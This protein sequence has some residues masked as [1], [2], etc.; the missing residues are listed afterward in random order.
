MIFCKIYDEKHKRKNELLDFS[1]KAEEKEKDVSLRIKNLFKSVKSS[2]AGVIDKNEHIDLEEGS[3]SFVVSELQNLYLTKANRSVISEAFEVFIG[4]S[5]KGDKGQFF[6]PRNVVNTI[7]NI[8]NPSTNQLIID[9]AC[10]SG[11]FLVKSLMSLWEKNNQDSVEYEWTKEEKSKRDYEIAANN[12][13]GIDKDAFL[14]K[15]T[16]AYMAIVG[17]G[18]SN[19][20]CDDSLKNLSEFQLRNKN[21]IEL[22]KFDFVLTNPPFGKKIKID[23]KKILRN[24]DLAHLWSNR[25]GQFIKGRLKKEVEPQIL[26]IERCVNLLRDGGVT[27][28]VLPES[29]FHAP[30]LKY[31]LHWVKKHCKIKAIIDLPFATFQ[32]YAGI[33]SCVLIAQK[34]QESEN[35]ENVIVMATAE[36]VGHDHRGRQTSA[37]TGLEFPDDLLSIQNEWKFPSNATNSNVMVVNQNEIIK[38]YY[39][40]RYYKGLK[41]IENE[42]IQ[43]GYEFEKI[44]IKEL[45][46]SRQLKCFNGLG[47]PKGESKGREGDAYYL[48]TS[49][50]I[51]FELYR[52][53]T[54]YIPIDEFESKLNSKNGYKILKFKDV[55]MVRRGGQRIGNIAMVSPNDVNDNILYASELLNFRV[56]DSTKLNPYLLLFLLSNDFVKK[57]IKYSTFIDSHFPNLDN[58]YLEI[59]LLFPKDQA[60]VQSITANIQNA[61]ENRWK[62]WDLLNNVVFNRL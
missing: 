11:E 20:L 5:L 46:E 49:D 1:F 30:S 27:A 14:A 16:K 48:R 37:I 33:K 19:I 51:N 29:I 42:T 45:I 6:T 54:T 25:D 2:Y 7:V 17:D 56:M 3:I 41:I 53:P 36:N 31:I 44:S 10:G 39:I 28:I 47:S 43:C 4:K 34:K 57:Q 40:P 59:Q 8:L 26:F 58:R 38:N 52:N 9:P 32:P 15:L 23:D 18:H 22:G 61:L 60:K 35:N 24:Y 12:I 55:L 21:K 62:S 50:I 13:F